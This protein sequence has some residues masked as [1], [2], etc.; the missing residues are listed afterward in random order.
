MKKEITMAK[1]KNLT[2]GSVCKAKE[3]GKPSYIRL[4]GD[5]K[6]ELLEAIKNM[7]ESKG[8]YLNLDSKKAQLETIDSLLESGRISQDSATKWRERLE[9][10]PDYV[11]F[12]VVLPRKLSD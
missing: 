8:L 11:L 7:D 10:M 3:K 9:K 12:D 5:L 6:N 2:V 4:R 1:Y